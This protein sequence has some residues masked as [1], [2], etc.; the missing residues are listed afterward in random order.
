MYAPAA[1]KIQ[2]G[3]VRL[4]EHSEYRERGGSRDKE[5]RR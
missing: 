2:G 3:E 5:E 1:R 4:R